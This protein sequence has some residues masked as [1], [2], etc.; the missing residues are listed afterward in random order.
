[1]LDLEEVSLF[2]GS[3]QSRPSPTTR[4]T[5]AWSGILTATQTG[6]PEYATPIQQQAAEVYRES[7]G[8]FKEVVEYTAQNPKLRDAL[9]S[10]YQAWA[11]E[12]GWLKPPMVQNAGVALG[13]LL[14][15]STPESAVALSMAMSGSHG[16]RTSP[17]A[18]GGLLGMLA[19][20]N[21]SDRITANLDSMAR[22]S[23]EYDGKSYNSFQFGGVKS[24]AMDVASVLA[25]P[26]GAGATRAVTLAG[27]VALAA[28]TALVN[29]VN[30]LAQATLGTTT[31]RAAIMSVALRTAEVGGLPAPVPGVGIYSTL[32]RAA[33][34]EPAAEPVSPSPSNATRM[35]VIRRNDADMRQLRDLWDDLGYGEILSTT[36]RQFIA[37]GLRPK[38]DEAWVKVFPEDAG[39]IGE[40]ITPHHIAGLPVTIP[41]PKT[42]H[43]NAHMP[44][45]FRYNPGGPGAAVPLYPAK[46]QGATNP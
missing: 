9:I 30:F 11:N 43:M 1:L 3:I 34:N 5:A 37:K 15:N 21:D 7:L 44:G 22:S 14:S 31:G 16:I 35:G 38:V 13:T 32:R 17:E 29:G 24:N 23:V 41:L 40:R 8:A 25:F 46:P 18:M 4:F 36:N 28:G 19:L 27:R 6:A 33:A 10:R 42:R 12:G 2:A 45:G 26:V 20:A 39:L